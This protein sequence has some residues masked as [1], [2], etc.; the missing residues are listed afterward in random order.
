MARSASF[1][2]LNNSTPL[3]TTLELADGRILARVG[4][5]AACFSRLT[6]EQR[7]TSHW[8]IAI[9]MF[10]NA[11]KEPSY[12]RAATLS[13]Q[14]ALLLDGNLASARSSGIS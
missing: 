6:D 4:D 14:T 11:L 5:V 2:E 8:T 9:R 1:S 12:L 13:L 10:N 3:P 7:A